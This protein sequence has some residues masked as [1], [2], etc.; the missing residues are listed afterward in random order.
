MREGKGCVQRLS[1]D[2]IDAEETEEEDGEE[3]EVEEGGGGLVR[4]KKRQHWHNKR[5]EEKEEEEE[6]AV[7]CQR[8]INLCCHGQISTKET[9]HP[10][11][12][13]T[14]ATSRHPG[15]EAGSIPFLK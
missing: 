3:R 5:G 12:V 4:A 6:E 9:N 10:G 1:L 8:G 15:M 14:A 11:S 2:L 7:A 13:P